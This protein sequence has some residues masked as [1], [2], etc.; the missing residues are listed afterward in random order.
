[1]LQKSRKVLTLSKVHV[2]EIKEGT[3]IKQGTCYRNQGRYLSKLHDTEIKE[4]TYIKQGTCY[5]DQGGYLH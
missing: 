5:R 1:M 4:G 2:T 3:Y